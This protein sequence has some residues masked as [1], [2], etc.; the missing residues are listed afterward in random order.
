M[1]AA[2]AEQLGQPLVLREVAMPAIGPD[3]VLLN[4][5]ACGVCYTDLRV[6][7][8]LGA[9][10]LPLIPGHEPVGIVAAVGAAVFAFYRVVRGRGLGGDHRG[11]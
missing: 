4:V 9:A 5:E 1:R 8:A 11:R 10:V 2:V 6:I 7:D 3:E